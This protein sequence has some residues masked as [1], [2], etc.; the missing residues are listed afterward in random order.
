MNRQLDVVFIR[1]DA[2][3]AIY[4][5]LANKFTA[6][7]PC[8]W[9]LLLAESCRSMG[10]G[11]A[12]IDCIAE[13][14][15]HQAAVQRIRDLNPR[16]VCFVTYGQNPNSGTTQME[17]TIELASLVKECYPEY[18][19][20]SIG[21]HTSS[22][23]HEVLDYKCFDFI[24]YNEGVK[25]LHSLLSTDLKTELDK[26]PALGWKDNGFNRL[27]NGA[28]SLVS[29]NEMDHLLPGYAWDLLP[30]KEKPLDVYRC[31]N[32]F[33]FYKEEGRSP[34]AAIYTS[35]GCVKKCE[36]CMINIVNRT[37]SSDGVHAAN[38]SVMRYWSPEWAFRQID[39]LMKMGVYNIRISDELF[40]LNRRY[41]EP[42][43]NSIIDAGYGDTFRTWT[44]SRI[45]TV[46][47]EYLEL[48]R[49]AGV[50]FLAYG[51]E[52]GNRNVR[53]EASKGLFKDVDISHIVKMTQDAGI[54]SGNN[55]IFGL[56]ED[57]IETMQETLDLALE[58]N[59]EFTNFYHCLALPGSPLYY[60]A[61]QRGWDMPKTFSGY[62]FHAYDAVP[63]PTKYLSGADVIRFRDQAWSK[64]FDRPS[65]HDLIEKKFGKSAV[66]GLKE[67]CKIKLKRKVLGD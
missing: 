20:M 4:Q 64:Y 26:V 36:Y 55:F 11:V 38:S 41:Y 42:L 35:L 16:L 33:N 45:D 59:G 8:T 51:I 66:D 1:G 5:A 23:P 48:F 10:Y 30:L 17:A 25:C 15:D 13:G 65:F 56:P 40:F 61:K 39:K 9:S 62:S 46:K 31:H 53:L 19:I 14:L 7:E 37:D 27:N 67:Q 22:L 57:T 29:T 18:P 52:A 6:I 21:T 49:K 63:L 43:L 2:Q 24:A 50:K 12:I 54:C 58:L 47:E 3:K 34:Y 60:E 44:Y 32:W 28:G